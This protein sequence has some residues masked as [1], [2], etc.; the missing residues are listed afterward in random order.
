MM[1]MPTELAHS[2][3][4]SPRQASHVDLEQPALMQVTEFRGT[5]RIG[6]FAYHLFPPRLF[7]FP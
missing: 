1:R 2:S 6:A 7:G 5:F 4:T 3:F